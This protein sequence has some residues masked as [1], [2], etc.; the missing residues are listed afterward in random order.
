[1]C[2]N[3]A[4]VVDKYPL[5]GVLNELVNGEI[6]KDQEFIMVQDYTKSVAQFG[7]LISKNSDVMKVVNYNKFNI[8]VIDSNDGAQ[9]LEKN[10]IN[11]VLAPNLRNPKADIFNAEP[12]DCWKFGCQWVMMNYQLYDDNM[13][14]YFEYFKNGGLVLKPAE[15]R[16]IPKPPPKIDPQ[17]KQASYAKRSFEQKGWFSFN[18]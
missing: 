8:T 13:K 7:G 6:T 18:M 9:P 17:S 5:I 14:K 4:I 2:G 15:I 10:P 3:I 16:Y 11:M 1:L 12:V